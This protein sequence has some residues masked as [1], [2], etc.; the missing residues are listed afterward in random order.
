MEKRKAPVSLAAVFR[1]AVCKGAFM[2]Q[3]SR[4]KHGGER[5]EQG[6]PMVSYR[7]RRRAGRI[8]DSA[9]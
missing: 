2:R 8:E 6:L 4:G 7:A 3:K 1:P 9:G 5:T